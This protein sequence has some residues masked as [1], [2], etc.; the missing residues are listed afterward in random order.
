M[1]KP[2]ILLV[3]DNESFVELFMCLPETEA[4]DIFPF[5]SAGAA[6]DFLKKSTVD[7]I[8]SDVQMPDM[9]GNEL[10]A[11]IQD[12]DPDIPFILVTAYGSM[13]KA[14]AAIRH[15]AYHYFQ[16]PL[17]DQLELFWTTV[18]EALEKRRR[19]KEIESLKREKSLRMSAAS[20]MIGRTPG[21]RQ[22]FQAVNDVAGLPVTVLIYGETGTGKELVAR[23]VHELS[24]RRDRGF[25]AVNC[26]EFSPGV[27]ESEL[28]GHERGAFTG[29]V[30]HK[31]G[32]FEIADRGT[33]FLDEIS[34]A[35]F[36]P[37]I[38]TVARAGKPRLQPSRRNR[39]HLLG[40]SGADRHQYPAG[41]PGGTSGAFRQDLLY[42]LNAYLLKYRRC[43]SERATFPCW[44][45]ITWTGS[46][47]PIA[48]RLRGFRNRPWP[49]WACMTGRATSANWSMSWN[50]R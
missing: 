37:A 15:G 41:D 39:H 28:F 29:A 49:P 9:S 2:K 32:L 13:E 6:L 22:V 20:A 5:T 1:E 11:A 3:D 36:R 35:L 10:L 26:N 33:L 19:L 8:L 7:L 24:D 14:V 12:M 40:F 18:R 25:F 48:G 43:G 21:L 38:Q 47:K 31:K 4:Y 23:A 30:G 45:N 46:A 34:N 27:L 42:R 44:P 50:G 17:D 16:K